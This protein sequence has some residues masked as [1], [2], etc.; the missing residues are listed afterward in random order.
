LIDAVLAEADVRL[1]DLA[2]IAVSIG[3]GSFTGLRIGLSVAKG[4]ALATGIPLVGV[5]T[6][7]AYAHALGPAPDPIWPVLDARTGEI[8]A[9]CFRWR[10]RPW[11]RRTCSNGCPHPVRW[12]ATRS[13]RTRPHGPRCP[14][15][16]GG[17]VLP[18][19]RQAE[20]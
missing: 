2:R 20:R 9:A 12:S 11:R 1:A 13:M 5:P 16:S 15:E 4:L 10:R 19:D 18:T 3:P 14:P 6:L 7:E 8:Y 17:S